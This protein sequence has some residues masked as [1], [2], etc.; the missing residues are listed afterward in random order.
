M[1]NPSILPRGTYF[2][3]SPRTIIVSHTQRQKH[4]KKKIH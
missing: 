3:H 2:L 1:I 4:K